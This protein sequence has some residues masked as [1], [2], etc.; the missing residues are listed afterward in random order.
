MRRIDDAERRARLVRRHLLDPRQRGETPLDAARAVG[1][2]HATDAVTVFLSVAARTDASVPDVERALY[3][4]RS[5]V[6]ML[7][8]RRTLFVVPRELVAVVFA[9]ATRAVAARER[10]RLLRFLRDSGIARPGPWLARAETAALEAVREL[11]EAS[12]REV[13]AAVPLLGRKVTLGAGTKWAGEQSAAA[14]VLPHLAMQGKLVRSRPAGT[15]TNA[16]FRWAATEAWLGAPIEER[17]VAE[18]QA[19]LAA[20]WLG[21]FG[22][23]TE[24][25]LRWWAGWTAR[26]ARAALGAVRHEQVELA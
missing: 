13:T 7:A 18:A 15:W 3:E 24:A 23:A 17:D 5:L 12:T 9:A 4:D 6:R 26:E 16:Q 11:G 22:P 20:V 8:M 1:V 14:R 2:L 19:E 10:T 25:D 21:A